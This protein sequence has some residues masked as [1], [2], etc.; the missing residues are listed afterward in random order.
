MDLRTFQVDIKNKPCYYFWLYQSKSVVKLSKPLLRK[1]RQIHQFWRI[2][3][4]VL[5]SSL[6]QLELH[7]PRCPASTRSSKIV[8]YFVISRRPYQV[9]QSMQILLKLVF[10][11]FCS[12]FC[13]HLMGRKYAQIKG[14]LKVTLG[15]LQ[16]ALVCLV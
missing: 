10:I 15:K 6:K 8:F 14:H 16:D 4:T 11:I 9:S 5:S 1:H 12:L 3:S 7:G 2:L 13:T